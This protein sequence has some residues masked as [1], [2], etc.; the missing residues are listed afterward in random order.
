MPKPH[1]YS[2]VAIDREISRSKSEFSIENRKTR[3]L[4]EIRIISVQDLLS[5]SYVLFSILF[6]FNSVYNFIEKKTWQDKYLSLLILYWRRENKRSVC[7]FFLEESVHFCSWTS[8]SQLLIA[9]CWWLWKEQQSI[10]HFA[11]SNT[12]KF[13]KNLRL[14]EMKSD[15]SSNFTSIQSSQI[16]CRLFHKWIESVEKFL[17]LSYIISAFAF[18]LWLGNVEDRLYC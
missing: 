14:I 11:F 8:R 6:L 3:M 9:S 16:F 5:H 4:L 10:C 15:Q 17:A 18:I 12:K 13:I 2:L 1:K 7:S